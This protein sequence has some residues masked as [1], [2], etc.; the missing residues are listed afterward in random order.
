MN[1]SVCIP[2]SKSISHRAMIAAAMADGESLLKGVLFCKDTD[3]TRKALQEL[4]AGMARRGGNLL[5][6]GNG[7]R[8]RTAAS[9][10]TLFVGNAGTSMRLLLSIMSLGRGEFLLDGSPRMRQRPVGVLV[11]AL[12]ELGA[13]VSFPGHEGYPPVLVKARGLPGGS[14]EIPGEESSQYLSSLLLAAPYA[15]KDTEIRVTGL[16]LSRPYVDMTVQVMEEFGA[17]VSRRGYEFFRVE[18]GYHYQPRTFAI[19]A[20]VSAA[21]YFWAGAAVTQGS[22]TTTNVDSFSTRQ[23]DTGFLDILEEMGCRVRREPGKVTVQ[24]GT[25]K[26]L[27]VDMGAMPD[28]VPTLAAVALFAQGKTT[29]RNVAHL[30]LKESDRLKVVAAEWKRLGARV[31]ELSDGLI[32]EGGRPLKGTV[33]DPHDDHRIAM[34][35]AVVGLKVPRLMIANEACVN[36]SFPTFWELWNTLGS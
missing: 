32:I 17:R 3:F 23:G 35:L 25:L 31:E 29:I 11:K 27:D 33:V 21:G 8:L 19:E 22:V 26:G 18:S 1:G 7:G 2:G 15:G 28:V 6:R 9:R 34:S 24:G 14:V 12:N 10:R 20:D 36:K 13:R 5:V 16:L 30:R 4:G